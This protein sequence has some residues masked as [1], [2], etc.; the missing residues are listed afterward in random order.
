MVEFDTGVLGILCLIDAGY[1]LILFGC[2]LYLVS[3]EKF[4]CVTVRSAFSSLEVNRN[5]LH[6]HSG[7]PMR[8]IRSHLSKL[9]WL[10]SSHCSANATRSKTNPVIERS[11]VSSP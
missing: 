8:D 5:S 11:V 4:A 3:C 6:L 7:G 1:K 9:Q 2:D 10:H